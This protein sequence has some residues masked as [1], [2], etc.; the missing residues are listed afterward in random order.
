MSITEMKK[1]ETA[2]LKNMKES[3][4]TTMLKYVKKLLDKKKKPLT[5]VT[6]FMLRL[7][8]CA[9]L[10]KQNPFTGREAAA[11]MSYTVRIQAFD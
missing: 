8:H 1:K 3:R 9:K 2:Y 5:S 11:N 10:S 7:E 6:V 4:K